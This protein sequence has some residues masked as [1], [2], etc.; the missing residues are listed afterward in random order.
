[1]I[2]CSVNWTLVCRGYPLIRASEWSLKWCHLVQQ[3]HSTAFKIDPSGKAKS[4]LC[5]V[6][7]CVCAWMGVLTLAL[8]IEPFGDIFCFSVT[9]TV[10]LEEMHAAP[11]L[12]SQLAWEM[13][14]AASGLYLRFIIFIFNWVYRNL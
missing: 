3:T 4:Y 13:L 8:P 1:M 12:N 2:Q 6:W 9:A 5:T 10:L 7:L 11:C 14:C